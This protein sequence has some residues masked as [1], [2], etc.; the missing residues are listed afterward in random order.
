MIVSLINLKAQYNEIRNEINSAIE[1][2]IESTAFINGKY[3][4]AFEQEFAQYSG[5]KYCIGVGNGTDALYITLK[6]PGVGV[7]DEVITVA[8][9]FIATSEAITATGAKVIFIDCNENDY[10]IDVNL[11]EGKITPRSKVIIPVHLFGQPAKIDEIL[12]IADKYGLKVVQDAAQAHGAL[13]KGRPI[14]AFA[15]FT[16][17]SFYCFKPLQQSSF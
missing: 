5:A 8:N 3:V 15:D 6:I 16:C 10:N 13:Y 9:S 1:E 4:K 12:A 2:V 17:F 7:G 11:I 14:A